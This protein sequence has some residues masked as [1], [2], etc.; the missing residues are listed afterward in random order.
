M[1][2]KTESREIIHCHHQI[3]RNQDNKNLT[4]TTSQLYLS[5]LDYSWVSVFVGNS[6]MFQWI[7]GFLVLKFREKFLKRHWIRTQPDYAALCG[8]LALET[9]FAINFSKFVEEPDDALAHAD[10]VAAEFCIEDFP[11]VINNSQV[12][13]QELELKQEKLRLLIALTKLAGHRLLKAWI[14]EKELTAQETYMFMSLRMFTSGHVQIHALANWAVNPQNFANPFLRR[15][16]IITVVY[17]YYGL[18]VFNR[19]VLFSAILLQ[20]IQSHT[21]GHSY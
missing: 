2:F 3:Q 11:C 21:Q 4:W 18:N 15:M 6:A 8:Q 16:S 13:K 1:I 17:N 12:G 10:G 7:W 19:V 9:H 5:F 20:T 14:G